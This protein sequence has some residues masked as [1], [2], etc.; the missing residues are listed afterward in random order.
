MGV[1]GVWF[2]FERRCA[3]C[4]G[5]GIS[6]EPVIDPAETHTDRLLATLRRSPADE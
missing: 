2:A 4:C 3:D 5:C 1:S 6:F